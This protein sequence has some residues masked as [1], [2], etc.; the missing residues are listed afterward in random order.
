MYEQMIIRQ[1]GRKKARA[2]REQRRGN[3]TRRGMSGCLSEE[4]SFNF[5]SDWRQ[6]AEVRMKLSLK[7]KAACRKAL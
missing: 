1:G 6:L 4:E 5:S 7:E 3:K 2:M